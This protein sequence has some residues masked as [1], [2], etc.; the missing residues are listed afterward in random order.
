MKIIN[1]A[2]K[3]PVAMTIFAS[4]IIILGVFTFTDIPL[5]L[6][7][8]MKLPYAAVITTYT[9]AGPEEVE[10]QVTEMIED[11]VGTLSGVKRIS[12]QSSAGQSLVLIEFD[13]G[14]DMSTATT[15]IREKV[16]MYEGYLPDGVDKPMVIKMDPTMMPIMQLTISSADDSIS[17]AQ[18]QTMADDIIEPRLARIP[19]V[20]SV[21]ITGGNVREV[22]V[23]VDPA[24]LAG[25]GLTL[26]QVN[27]VLAAENFNQS[28]GKVERGD[29]K[30]YIRTLQQ[31][32]SID[33]IRDVAITTPAGNTVFL[34]EIATIVDGFK[35]VTQ[36]TRV[37]GHATVS[38]NCMKQSDANTVDTCAA[39]RDEMAALQNELP[40]HL[41]VNFVM[42]QSDFINKSL[43][44]TKR[45]IWEGALLAMLI[46]YVFLRNWRS[47][48]IIVSAIPM[49][50]IATFIL[51]YFTDNTLNLITLGG[52]ALGVGRMV[53]DSIV[54]FEN[55]YRHREMGLDAVHAALEGGS[56]VGQAVIAST[57]TIVAVFAPMVFTTGIAGVMFKPLAITVSFA[58]L[59]SLFVS[60]TIVP[61]LS[62]RML[63]DEGMGR[64]NLNLGRFSAW[65]DRTME[66]LNGLGVRYRVLLE[67]ALRHRGRV[68]LVVSALMLF[69]VA[70]CFTP[71]IGAEFIPAMDSGKINISVEIDKGSKLEATDEVIAEIEA[72][73]REM[74]EVKSI[75]TSVGGTGSSFMSGT[76]QTETGAIIVTLTDVSTFFGDGRKKDVNAV[77]E[78]IRTSLADIPGL[79]MSVT[80]ADAA[81]SGGMTGGADVQIQVHGD[82]MTVLKELSAQVEDIVRRT[83]GTRE[84]SSSMTG[85][86]PEY[87]IRI[88][89]HR[90]AAVG[91]SPAA[92]AAEIKNAMSGSVAT[93]YRVAGDEVDVRV[94][95]Q[96][97]G[98]KNMEY[99]AN[100]GITTPSG[101]RIPLSELASFE[102]EEGASSINR[103]DQTRLASIE[104]YLLDDSYSLSTV[105][106][107]IQAQ[108]DTLNLPAG[109]TITYEGEMDQMMDSFESLLWAFLLA[110]ILVYAV[111]AVQYESF[112]NPFVI[113]FSV[114]TALIG[115]VLS[116]VLMQRNF[117]VPA[118][119]GVIM[120]V[121]IA[122]SNAIV[123]VDYLNQLR[124][125]GME[126]TEAVL[127][128]GQVRLRPI[129]MTALATILAMLPMSLGIQTGSESMAPVASA[130]I[131]G[132]LVS[133]LVTLVLVPVIYTLLEDMI[134]YV[135]QNFRR[136]KLAAVELADISVGDVDEGDGSM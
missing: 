35:E 69:T 31:F 112:F 51:M 34:Y 33:D 136:Q 50:I 111:M 94:R 10:S 97:E 81:S 88:D 72:R 118:F 115:V 114:P 100:L 125:G 27:Q 77:A 124:Q 53:D 21:Y 99:L 62:S 1:F 90:A 23:E 84:V 65:L 135:K 17:L 2:V 7:P 131:G 79:K 6:Y 110:L 58:I 18:L 59:C 76:E 103:V 39:I 55:I 130:V 52:L 101:A 109:Y 105:V 106:A 64:H 44:N 32:E 61:L 22:Q 93:R 116:L 20:A 15:D 95:Y 63:N 37:D 119:I 134:N 41:Q 113:M 122:V 30:Y 42:D 57:L 40:G 4:V 129:L 68:I 123:Y 75:F 78:E 126:M 87:Q 25:Y 26:G 133:T 45:M 82:D 83:P 54:V 3:R 24:K 120:L 11:S 74:P 48:I 8:E 46:I 92:I 9:G 16:G 29:T 70:I 102:I 19:Q 96:T 80:V 13:W 85:G 12:S 73:L 117:S 56:Q 67:A 71:L 104:A 107:D 108:A 49:S 14:T 127:E 132:L 28:S 66:F 47:T 89:R 38:V 98:G 128:A 43:D 86:N 91:L 36:K 121:G 5:D 60:L